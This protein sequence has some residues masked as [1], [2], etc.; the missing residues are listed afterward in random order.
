MVAVFVINL[1]SIYKNSKYGILVKIFLFLALTFLSVGTYFC[2]APKN[3]V[4]AEDDQEYSFKIDFKREDDGAPD[5]F[6]GSINIDYVISEAQTIENPD[7]ALNDDGS[8]TFKIKKS[9][10][11][12]DT[13][14]Y[15]KFKFV[16]DSS[17]DLYDHIGSVEG[18][19]T[20]INDETVR[21][22]D[23]WADDEAVREFTI[24]FA[25][26]SNMKYTKAKING[27]G[28]SAFM[29][30]VSIEEGVFYSYDCEGEADNVNYPI[31]SYN[32]DKGIIVWESRELASGQYRRRYEF[33]IGYG[34]VFYCKSGSSHQGKFGF[35]SSSVPNGPC[36]G[37]FDTNNAENI[38]SS[39]LFFMNLEY[40][41]D[42]EI[43]L[44]TD[45][46]DEDYMGEI[47]KSISAKE[48]LPASYGYYIYDQ[49]YIEN[50]EENTKSVSLN[51]KMFDTIGFAQ[52][53]L[54]VQEGVKIS[55]VTGP[56]IENQHYE[57]SYYIFEI[58]GRP[59][60]SGT[61]TI[62]TDTKKCDITLQ[63]PK[64][65]SGSTIEN[66]KLG[67]LANKAELFINGNKRKEISI[68][69]DAA[70]AAFPQ[71]KVA[72]DFGEHD[73][74][75]ITIKL[76][77]CEG[78]K[79][80]AVYN[81]EESIADESGWDGT[82]GTYTFTIKGYPGETVAYTIVGEFLEYPLTFKG[83][84]DSGYIIDD[85][86]RFNVYKEGEDPQSDSKQVN[87]NLKTPTNVVIDL[88]DKY[89][90]SDIY[91][92]GRGK[93]H[94]GSADYKV[95][96][97]NG[98]EVI[99]APVTYFNMWSS[100]TPYYYVYLGDDP[101]G[102]SN[103]DI[104]YVYNFK[105]ND[106]D[107]Y[108]IK[109]NGNDKIYVFQNIDD[110]YENVNKHFTN[111]ITTYSNIKRFPYSYKNDNIEYY[112]E[113]REGGKIVYSF[114]LLNP[115]VDPNEDYIIVGNITVNYYDVTV[116]CDES[117]SEI[118]SN[119]RL[120][121]EE[122]NSESHSVVIKNVSAEATSTVFE[123][124][125]IQSDELAK[126]YAE[127]FS[128]VE[129]SE[130]VNSSDVEI[131]NKIETTITLGVI[132]HDC[133][134]LLNAPP[135]I[136]TK[137]NFEVETKYS[138]LL[139][140][141]KAG[142][143]S[144][145]E[146][147]TKGSLLDWNNYTG[148]KKVIDDIQT[149][150]LKDTVFYYWITTPDNE[151]ISEE[152]NKNTLKSLK[153]EKITEGCEFSK[154]PS[155]LDDE[156]YKEES[157]GKYYV[158]A[159]VVI[160]KGT[161]PSDGFSAKILNVSYPE[162]KARFISEQNMAIF[163]PV[164][165][166]INLESPS[167]FN[168]ISEEESEGP[169][170]FNTDLAFKVE[171]STNYEIYNLEENL[172]I[173][174]ESG[175]PVDI[176]NSQ[177][178]TN[179]EGK[180][181]YEITLSNVKPN[182]KVEAKFDPLHKTVN[183]NN[184][185]GLIYYEATESGPSAD[186]AHGKYT[187]KTGDNFYF[188]VKAEQGYN[189]EAATVSGGVEQ[190]GQGS[191]YKLYKIKE[192]GSDKEGIYSDHTISGSI[193]KFKYNVNFEGYNDSETPDSPG[194]QKPVTYKKDGAEI[195]GNKLE[196][197]YGDNVSFTVEISPKYN[198]SNFK[199]K[200]YNTDA[201]GNVVPGD[202]GTEINLVGG[203]YSVVNITSH[204]VIKVEG[205]TVNSYNVN[206]VKSDAIKFLYKTETGFE[207][208]SGVQSVKYDESAIFKVE[209]RTG[210]AVTDEMKVF[211]ISE[212]GVRT[213]IKSGSDGTYSISGIKE[214]YEIKIEDVENIMFKVVLTAT[215][216]VT[217]LNEGGAVISGTSKVKYGNNFEF[218][219]AIDDAYDDS[220]A[221]MYIIVN[222]G[223]SR[224]LSAQKL[225]TGRYI[226]S[227]ITED[228]VIKVGN[229]R[230]NSYTVTLTKVEGMDYY[231]SSKKVI[232]GDN[233]VNHGDSLSFKV[234]LHSAYDGSGV[235]VMLGNEE[236]KP[237][238]SGFYT[239]PKVI[240]NKTVTILGVEENEESKV[241]NTI[242]NL[243]S[244]VSNL[245]DVDAVIAATKDYEKLSDDQK[246]RVSNID[247]LKRLQEQVK[248]F[249]HVSNDVR[250]SGVDWRIKLIAVPISFDKE[251]CTRIYKKLNS[252]YIISLYDVY[253]WDTIND[254]KYTLP[255]GQE[256]TIT[257]PKPDLT[258]FE[259][260]TGIHEKDGGKISFLTLSI[261]SEIVRFTTDSFSPMGIIA[262]R[263]ST[264]G[265]SSLLDAADANVGLIRDY[266]LSTFGS[267]NAGNKG[268][269]YSDI[270]IND[271]SD[272]TNLDGTTGNINEKFKSRNNPVT[273]QGS[274]IRLA[275][276]LMLLILLAIIIIIVI[277]GIKRRK[278]EKN[279]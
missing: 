253:L 153:L 27:S 229:I 6:A 14:G 86:N 134:I 207:E 179:D 202:E 256:A 11:G 122:F 34:N 174:T 204:K 170:E 212:S 100:S 91:L 92:N 99:E 48:L 181:C 127:W 19:G 109:I 247:V 257:L 38:K 87:I 128:K 250:I 47:I 111:E 246:Q 226:I 71:F 278:K 231:N 137:I 244:N 270:N 108:L 223:K 140:V 103:L 65:E 150:H 21:L 113:S 195:P 63:G 121:G 219:V 62:F 136:N 31:K 187:V 168:K 167:S 228:V 216:G 203:K 196:V 4:R 139:K 201:E 125:A 243:P 70:D 45:P 152:E 220:I 114:N 29:E 186:K 130:A 131:I 275:L 157:T 40:N 35:W 149:S 225:A 190:I 159:K 28:R 264:P 154:I 178:Y 97:N 16:K 115:D 214:D 106:V 224:N 227:N 272:S 66:Q 88:D 51:T 260:P 3:E 266:A 269:S 192:T 41:S 176:Y 165:G 279:N 112:E 117:L 155:G 23:G 200:E 95:Q 217:Y 248:E 188:A 55:N 183:F 173:T 274:A 135:L 144:S 75:T 213:E 54:E 259:K 198:K 13:S 98:D 235:K 20:K 265:R 104:D 238:D 124:T 277:E 80:V 74:D 262:N 33:F 232:N 107:H 10:I 261:G 37:A 69:E 234:G 252:E 255:E 138:D 72:A 145:T 25:Y 101:T 56:N 184:I 172:E 8:Y 166:W 96:F 249:H 194:A 209:A 79:I 59:G 221:G 43:T 116:K 240:E 171:P 193:V 83:L 36:M 12:N 105:I 197:E 50:I 5:L 236:L 26:S 163:R 276:V 9:E 160:S 230:K 129:P 148:K 222:D 24:K 241:I 199:I 22:N 169:F 141:Y 156:P 211:S 175:N 2:F 110:P 185:E 205:I 57:G 245:T 147:Y 142:Y 53:R 17:C 268:D 133:E 7:L 123:L 254:V 32:S 119:L 81:G 78:M 180:S 18:N 89:S 233:S 73:T 182:I 46:S 239:V 177:E 191:D 143:N 90:Q 263:S 30:G 94:C 242:N 271:G 146:D 126:S 164:S 15:F 42:F 258:Y 132:P 237:N 58:H 206:F 208:K 49:Q 120:N 151:F 67:V 158:L 52:I 68:N 251:A 1:K 267:G 39:N 61:Y 44:Q 85:D 210:Y 162:R 60:D 64:D 102:Y 118:A 189:L 84:N 76:T 93:F 82:A 161:M 215:D 77:A 273:A 218:S